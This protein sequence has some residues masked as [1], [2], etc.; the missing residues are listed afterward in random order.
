MKKIVCTVFSLVW[1]VTAF[2]QSAAEIV[3][4]MQDYV[5]EHESEGISFKENLISFYNAGNKY[6]VISDKSIWYTDFD[7]QRKWVYTADNKEIETSAATVEDAN[8]IGNYYN[9][10]DYIKP[11]YRYKITAETDDAWVITGKKKLL[12]QYQD[13]A[14]KVE[15]T[16]KKD[17]YQPVSVAFYDVI[18]G[19]PSDIVEITRKTD[20]RFGVSEQEVTFNSGDYPDVTFI[21]SL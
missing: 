13:A 16:I 19:E 7:N 10:L 1:A 11:A 6:C 12:T 20:I 2:S 15:F 9:G 18:D 8:T 17:T 3:L 21:S 5:G 4:K 14:K